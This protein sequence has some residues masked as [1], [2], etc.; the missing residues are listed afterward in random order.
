MF[1]K[2]WCSLALWHEFS[3]KFL[4]LSN[5]FVSQNQK[6]KRNE[7]V[8]DVLDIFTLSHSVWMIFLLFGC[9][10]LFGNLLEFCWFSKHLKKERKQEF[11]DK[12]WENFDVFYKFQCISTEN[13]SLWE[14]VECFQYKLCKQ[15][16]SLTFLEV[17]GSRETLGIFFQIKRTSFL[18]ERLAK[19]RNTS[20]FSRSFLFYI[21]SDE[22]QLWNGIYR[23]HNRLNVVILCGFFLFRFDLKA[24]N[25]ISGMLALNEMLATEFMRFLFFVLRNSRT[26]ALR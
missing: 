12:K 8:E 25:W 1:V 3:T 23:K 14:K 15:K 2:S 4:A 9:R 22:I 24:S 19:R 17:Y 20:I 5:E 16:K 11:T 21:C 13:N 26:F 18:T 6:P 7:F 10:I